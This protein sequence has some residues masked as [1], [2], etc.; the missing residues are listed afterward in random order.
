M[1]PY[2]RLAAASFA[3]SENLL[4]DRVTPGK[5]SDRPAENAL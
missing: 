5:P 3:A 4:N 2:N 1:P